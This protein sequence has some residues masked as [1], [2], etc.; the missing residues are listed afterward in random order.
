MRE[1]KHEPRRHH[2]RG[3]HWEHRS[4]EKDGKAYRERDKPEHRFKSAQTFR[5]GRAIAFLEKLEVKRSTLLEQLNKPEYES[6]KQVISGEL[7][8]TDTIIQEFIHTFELHE[9]VSDK[10]NESDEQQ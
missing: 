1:D 6:I 3:E 10:E 2:D 4:H 7:K 8:A 5:R 9:V